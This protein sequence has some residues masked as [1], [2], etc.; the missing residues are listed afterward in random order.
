MTHR[1]LICALVLSSVGLLASC[2]SDKATIS[3]AD[4]VTKGNALCTALNAK[5]DPIT[6]AFTD[7]TTPE[8][9]ST[10]ITG[11]LVPEIRK[12]VSAVRAL[13]FPKGDEAL[14]GGVMDETEKILDS[15]A[16]DPTVALQGDPLAVPNSK[17]HDYGLTV[18]GSNSG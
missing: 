16:K 14:L 13:G 2:G 9:L 8:E 10:F 12:T 6:K 5:L 18:C 1:G 3:K 4:F 17:L 15:M 11:V 7:Q